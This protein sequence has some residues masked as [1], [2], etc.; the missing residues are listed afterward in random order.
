MGRQAACV[1]DECIHVLIGK[2]EGK[3]LLGRFWCGREYIEVNL[4]ETGG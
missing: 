4:R 2:P 1:G 3:T